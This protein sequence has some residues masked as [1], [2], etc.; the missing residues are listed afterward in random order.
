[1]KALVLLNGIPPSREL[2]L[3]EA[4]EA[5]L[6]VAADGAADYAMDYGICP[7][8]VIGDMD[9]IKNRRQIEESG[10]KVVIFPREKDEVDSQLAIDL[11]LERGVRTITLLGM[12]GDRLDH[13]Y[14]NIMLMLRA[15]KAGV[16]IRAVDDINDFTV[17][18]G[19]ITINGAPGTIISL[20]P[21][22]S[23]VWVE[24]TKGLKY[25]VFNKLMPADLPYGVSNVMT[26]NTA[27]VKVKWGYLMV[28]KMRQSQ[29]E[30]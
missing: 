9:S 13:S 10:G 17:K 18:S 27:C 19:N 1:M 11:A 22:G 12:T 28:V 23:D 26:S 7:H 3:K 20:L 5:D 15:A 24:S 25:G 8:V 21:V 30:E 29:A 2:F 4:G 16:D 14:A 6:I